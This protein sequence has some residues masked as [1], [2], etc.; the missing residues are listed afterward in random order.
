[1]CALVSA[2]VC[3]GGA[4]GDG[5]MHPGEVAVCPSCAVGGLTSMV[6]QEECVP[7]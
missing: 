7:G 6:F 1:M 3:S 5:C 4:L 2:M